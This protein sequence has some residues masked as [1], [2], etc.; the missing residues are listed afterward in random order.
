MLIDAPHLEAPASD[1]LFGLSAAHPDSPVLPMR[2]F[3][4]WLAARGRTQ[5]H[6]VTRIP[7]ADMAGWQ[8]EPETGNLV[9]DSGRFFSIE[10]LDVW[11]DRTWAGHWQQP[12][13]VQPE[14][15][16]L[17]ILVRRID[18]VPHLLMQAK[19]EPGNVNGIQLSPTVQATWSNY[20]GVHGGR[21]VPY[22]NHFLGPG[23]GRTVV[24]VLQSEQTAWYLHK[25]NRNMIVEVT[26]PVEARDGFCWLT[27]GQ[28]R[29]LLH[30]DHLVN[31]D[32]RTVLAC[33]PPPGPADVVPTADPFR[34]ALRDSL[35][36]RG[37]PETPTPELLSW[38]TDIRARR[39]LVQRRVPL[40]S[41]RAHGW[42][43]HPDE[44]AHTDGKYFRVIGVHVQA[45]DREVRS[46]S[47][48]LIEPVEPGVVALIVK[49]VDGVLHAL[50]QA[51]IDA[52]AANVAE[53]APT[54]NC[55]PGNYVGVPA[56]FRP[57]FLDHVLAAD[58]RR[59]RYD[60]M[61]S[62]EGG[63]FYHAHNRYVVLEADPD[64]ATAPGRY[65]RWMTLHQLSGLLR[66]Y[67]YLNVELRSVLAGVH[68]LDGFGGL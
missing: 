65:H 64:F 49:P 29:R 17:G 25:R 7:L 56:P 66:H 22:L 57:P 62:E 9:H 50:V 6:R 19:M 52:G 60:V 42:R 46:W 54:V 5:Q 61:L 30:R 35:R 3:D 68:T 23:A 12:I 63:R 34:A 2:E 58:P 16:V 38:L 21:D 40:H 45:G 14:V 13:I 39:R 26:G 15:G 31:M 33:I 24:D 48:P 4:A 47:Q 37:R 41:A 55:Q 59:I 44:I 67:N 32:A 11:T 8:S 28:V 27:L 1:D 36:G 18:G 53:L 51:R 43:W 20:T 10:G